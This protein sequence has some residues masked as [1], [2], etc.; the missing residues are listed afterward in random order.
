MGEQLST[1]SD[2]INSDN[3]IKPF[4]NYALQNSVEVHLEEADTIT[5]DGNLEVPIKWTNLVDEETET[6][7]TF[8]L[9]QDEMI[10]D[11]SISCK[12]IPVLHIMD[13]D[14]NYGDSISATL[15]Y[16]MMNEDSINGN[17]RV[18]IFHS[19]VPVKLNGRFSRKKKKTRNKSKWKE[20][21]LKYKLVM[22][23]QHQCVKVDNGSI[24]KNASYKIRCKEKLHK[25]TEY[26]QE[27]L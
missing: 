6:D 17:R 4:I 21:I 7:E 2:G 8:I 11:G 20:R 27:L 5:Y 16:K 1:I 22:M 3:Y 9:E 25:V 19:P 24:R 18:F 10:D 15:R 23:A 14:E 26:D 12:I 13:Q